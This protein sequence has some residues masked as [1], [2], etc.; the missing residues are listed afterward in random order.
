V[1]PAGAGKQTGGDGQSPEAIF[2][3]HYLNADGKE[4]SLCGNGSRCAAAHA[5]RKGYF[6]GNQGIFEASDGEHRVSQL[7]DG[8]FCLEM[9]VPMDWKV[10][11]IGTYMNT[12]SPHLVVPVHDLVNYPVSR[13][14]K[15]L[16]D[17]PLFM[18]GGTNVNFME[19]IDY[20]SLKVRTYERG[21]EA[22]TLSCGTG[23]VACALLHI[24]Q[25]SQDFDN[26][27]AEVHLQFRGGKMTVSATHDG[28]GRMRDIALF[29]PAHCSFKGLWLGFPDKTY[30]W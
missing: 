26:P 10:L 20:N 1:L 5:F 2:Y 9:R 18:P 30:T 14:G 12:G 29:G 4:G 27:K 21:V 28:S 19:A 22:E 17:H 24:Q 3:L 16:R 7:G 6:E 23:A 15:I 13:E 25:N 11:E 8:Y